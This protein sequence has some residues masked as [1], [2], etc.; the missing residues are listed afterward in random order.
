MKL[1][2]KTRGFSLFEFLVATFLSMFLL[3]ILWQSYL[4]AK[5]VYRMQKGLVE[6]SENMRFAEFI[7]WQGITQA[8]FAGC[9]S[10]VQ[11]NFSN[12][13]KS[14]SN[15]FFGIRGYDSFNVP[16]YILKSQVVEGTD[17]IVIGK[18][19]SRATV[20][21]ND[22]RKNAKNANEETCSFQVKNQLVSGGEHV[23]L[24]SDCEKAD[25]FD[26]TVSH[27]QKKITTDA[28]LVNKYSRETAEIRSFEEMTFFIKNPS[29]KE[30]HPNP[31]LYLGVT[32]G[33]VDELVPNVINMQVSY[34]FGGSSDSDY[35]KA[36]SINA[37]EW[38]R[39]AR[40]R[41]ELTMHTNLKLAQSSKQ[42]RIDIK[43]RR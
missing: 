30:G 42:K 8:G 13:V 31:G 24:I 35:V 21:A 6:L 27:D 38:H 26:A 1:T 40:V 5:N 23:L 17:V 10:I 14:K 29:D 20:L 16:D 36:N 25:L 3:V 12:Q 39:V 19:S 15:L 43:L 11:P 18:A 37:N 32:R 7:L 33:R 4:S 22:I 9:R 2:E 41:I 34:S 28:K